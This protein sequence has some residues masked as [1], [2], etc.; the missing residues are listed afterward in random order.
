[1][2]LIDHHCE[3]LSCIDAPVSVIE[4]FSVV[5]PAYNEEQ[6][7]EQ[8]LQQLCA[9]LS[10]SPVPY[11][12][13]V[14]DDGS[15]DKTAA[16][17]G[18]FRGIRL[19]SHPVNKGYGAAL[20]TGIRFAEHNLIC[21]T[22]ADG[23]YPNERILEL[24]DHMQRHHTDMIVGARIGKHVHIPLVRRPA[25]W[26]VAQLANFVCD[27]HIPDLNSG[28]RVFRRQ[29]ILPFWNMLP[30]GFSFTTT[31]TLC[32]LT[33]A[34]LV[35]YVPI[36]YHPRSGRSKIRPIRDTINFL[37]LI[38]RMALFFNPLKIFIPLSLILLIIAVA[39]GLYTHLVIGKMADM[40]TAIIALTGVQCAMLGLLAEMITRR[41][42]G[43]GIED[44]VT[45][46]TYIHH[47]QE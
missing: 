30:N 2:R 44:I 21:I 39:A 4:G 10:D 1:M 16:I 25:K 8:V 27:Q 22:D 20:K 33:N 18:S 41:V 35:E 34:Y 29:S 14:V 17:L 24:I 46:N 3:T 15:R 5:I 31:I 12:I 47:D 45:M 36:D 42:P 40:T 38:M 13:I 28:F 26:F 23:T 43:A 9:T 19:I 7:I 37:K 32:M 11:E 6:G